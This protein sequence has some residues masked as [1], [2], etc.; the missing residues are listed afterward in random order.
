MAGANSSYP[1]SKP[2]KHSRGIPLNTRYSVQGNWSNNVSLASG[3]EDDHDSRP[4]ADPAVSKK[5]QRE[6]FSYGEREAQSPRWE[7]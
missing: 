7:V 2:S 1:S 4:F 3:Q 6:T 5:A